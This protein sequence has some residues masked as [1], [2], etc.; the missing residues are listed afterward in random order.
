MYTTVKTV[1][2]SRYTPIWSESLDFCKVWFELTG[3]V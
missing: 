2:Q 3:V 1:L